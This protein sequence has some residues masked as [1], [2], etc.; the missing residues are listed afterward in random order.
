V[1]FTIRAA[2]KLIA[3][4]TISVGSALFL[5]G[6]AS[7]PDLDQ[8]VDVTYKDAAGTINVTVEIP[9][10][11]CSAMVGVNMFT[12]DSDGDRANGQD[13]LARTPGPDA[14]VGNLFSLALGD[15]LWFVST[16]DFE[17]DEKS[18]TLDGLEGMVS[19]VDYNDGASDFGDAVDTAATAIGTL[20]CTT[21]D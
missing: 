1:T 10:I 11:E 6:C 9:Q 2:A 17:G 15:G 12:A 5:A 18:F 20:E 8:S 21:T 19:P 3:L 16:N 7:T 14:E 4:S 13:L